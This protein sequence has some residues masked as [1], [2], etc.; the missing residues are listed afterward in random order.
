[1]PFVEPSLLG[2]SIFL[3]G[4]ERDAEKGSNWGGSGVLVGI[5][6]EVNPS[7]VHLYAVTNDHVA[8]RCSV[9]RLAK[10]KGAPFV[11]P[12]GEADWASHPDG[13]D[14]SIRSLGAAVEDEYWYVG[15]RLFLTEAD[16]SP[17]GIGP[18]DDCLM[19]GRYINQEF[20]QFDRPVVRFG[21]IAMLPEGVRQEQRSFDQ[22]SFLVDMRSHSGFSGSPVFVYYETEGWRF[23][24][25]LAEVPETEDPVRD[26]EA[27]VE[28]LEQR[29]VGRETSGIMGKTW[30]LGIDWGRLPIWDDVFDG[31]RKIGR[32][33]ISSGMAG[34]VPAWKLLDLLN[35]DEIRAARDKAETELAEVSEA[36]NTGR[37]VGPEM[38]HEA[39][40]TWSGQ[41]QPSSIA[42]KPRET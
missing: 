25:P 7:R 33:R 20:R 22:E 3:Y 14:I 15:A 13:D 38:G 37:R 32:M 35:R 36:G 19:V 42:R 2:S 31:G 4:T 26:A 34:V 10:R 8:R 28:A 18:G 5:P 17:E 30:L 27:K 6:S 29:V 12:G 39:S 24:P 1:V 41:S 9:V 40:P 16:I 11:L 21:N 23:L